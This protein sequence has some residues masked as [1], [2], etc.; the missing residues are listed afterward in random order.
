MDPR[1]D[2]VISCHFSVEGSVRITATVEI[3]ADDKVGEIKKKIV[4]D[5]LNE[6]LISLLDFKTREGTQ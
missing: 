1:G 5:L 3:V 2:D 4:L 6:T